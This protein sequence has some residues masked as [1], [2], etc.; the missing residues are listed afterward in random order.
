[1]AER[2]CIIL[3]EWRVARSYGKIL[4]C[5]HFTFA[6]P[7]RHD[8]TEYRERTFR[9]SFLTKNRRGET[10]NRRYVRAFPHSTR[11]T[12]PSDALFSSIATAFHRELRMEDV[13]MIIS[14]VEGEE[15]NYR[16]NYRDYA[17]VIRGCLTDR[18]T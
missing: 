12:Y 3:S 7:L 13:S 5:A 10:W 6:V 14:M 11:Y 16:R 18:I 9:P 2:Y 4:L 1:M 17:D 8:Y 15:R